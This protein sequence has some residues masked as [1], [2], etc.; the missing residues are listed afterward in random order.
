MTPNELS[1]VNSTNW[2][3][4]KSCNDVT[5]LRYKKRNS[6]SV[7]QG[8]EVRN[9]DQVKAKLGLRADLRD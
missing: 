3:G 2:A 8:A 1:L 6:R 5:L 7:R 4:N 9:P